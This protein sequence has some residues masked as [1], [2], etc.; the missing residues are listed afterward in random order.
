MER[1]MARAFGHRCGGEPLLTE[2]AKTLRLF[3]AA[4]VALLLY[5]RRSSLANSAPRVDALFPGSSERD[6]VASVP[7]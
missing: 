7:A 1:R 2:L 5:R 4:L 3:Q 6:S